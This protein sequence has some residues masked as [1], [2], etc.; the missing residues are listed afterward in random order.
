CMF[1]KRAVLDSAT[2]QEQVTLKASLSAPADPFKKSVQKMTLTELVEAAG[3]E[4][5]EKLKVVLLELGNRRGDQAIAA[6][7][8][9]AA[10]Y[11]GDMQKLAREMLGKQLTRLKN[12]AVKEK[13][14]DDRVEVRAA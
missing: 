10:T 4:R 14:V 6:L 12:E 3:K 7:G 2:A 8:S 9:A 1:R 5:E 11:D 13:F